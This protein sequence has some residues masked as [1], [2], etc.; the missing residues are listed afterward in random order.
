MEYS[1]TGD[2]NDTCNQRRNR[3]LDEASEQNQGETQP[4]IQNCQS[5]SNAQPNIIHEDH[6]ENLN[7]KSMTSSCGKAEPEEHDQSNIQQKEQCLQA[8]IISKK[9]K[10]FHAAFLKP[11]VW[12]H[13]TLAN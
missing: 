13:S 7:G 4:M 5:T 9:M 10:P 1:R 6:R 3:S 12:P 2:N 11:Q 8:H